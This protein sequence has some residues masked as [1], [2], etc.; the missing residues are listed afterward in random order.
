MIA[1]FKGSAIPR[2]SEPARGCNEMEFFQTLGRDKPSTAPQKLQEKRDWFLVTQQPQRDT[3]Y[4]TGY[5]VGGPENPFQ[6]NSGK[7]SDTFW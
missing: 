1:V 2:W 6:N 7:K 5:P 4:P 3:W